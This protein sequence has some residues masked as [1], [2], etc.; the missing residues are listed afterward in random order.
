MSNV[1]NSIAII[2]LAIAVLINSYNDRHHTHRHAAR[3]A[4]Q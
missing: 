1:F 3:A 4:A 2:F